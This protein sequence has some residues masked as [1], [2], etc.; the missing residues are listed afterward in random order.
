MEQLILAIIGVIITSYIS[1][2]HILK[3]NVVCPIS[4]KSCNVVLNSKYSK[5]FV[6]K[7]EFIGLVYY[8]FII[9]TVFLPYLN[10]FIILIKIISG[11]AALYSIILFTIQI[12]IIKN[13]CF[14]C[15]FTAIINVGIF[16]SLMIK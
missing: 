13:Y 11:L 16:I 10:N 8:I 5:T 9:L 6:I 3:R 1:I 4:S 7:N 15:I 2:S 14:W 12:K